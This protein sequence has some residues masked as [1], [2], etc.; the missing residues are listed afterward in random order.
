MKVMEGHRDSRR[1]KTLVLHVVDPNWNYNTIWYYGPQAPPGHIT[2]HK[3]GISTEHLPESPK[4]KRK[5]KVRLKSPGHPQQSSRKAE[6]RTESLRKLK[7]F[8]NFCPG[9]M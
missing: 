7:H 6:N 3:L 1:M 2:E 4:A 8:L 9:S 5:L